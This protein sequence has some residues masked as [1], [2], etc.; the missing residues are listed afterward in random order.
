MDA[1]PP[2][3]YPRSLSASRRCVPGGQYPEPL[4]VR[5]SPRLP[6]PPPSER[7]VDEELTGTVRF[8]DD[9]AFAMAS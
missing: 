4:P 7:A 8:D 2:M 5:A 1:N 6:G 9:V 3:A